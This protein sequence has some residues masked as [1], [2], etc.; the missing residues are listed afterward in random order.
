LAQYIDHAWLVVIADGGESRR[1]SMVSEG[2][3]M[4]D[5]A[6]SCGIKLAGP[7]V[8]C[9]CSRTVRQDDRFPVPEYGNGFGTYVDGIKA[10]LSFESPCKWGSVF[11]VSQTK[12]LFIEV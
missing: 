5:H 7:V 8:S 2:T 12:L 6:S 11:F 1:A 3:N 9:A 4:A 10:N